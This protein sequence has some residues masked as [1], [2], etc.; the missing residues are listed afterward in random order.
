MNYVAFAGILKI[1]NIYMETQLKFHKG[2]KAIVD[3]PSKSRY[4]EMFKDNKFHHRFKSNWWT[5]MTESFIRIIYKVVYF[6]IFPLLVIPMGVIGW[7]LTTT[8]DNET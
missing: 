2:I 4:L 3:E 7:R 1:D 8:L 6:Y 5:K